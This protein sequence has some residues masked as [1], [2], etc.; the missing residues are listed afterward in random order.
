ML[1]DRAETQVFQRVGDK[2]YQDSRT[3]CI[4]NM[5]KG[6]MVS[7]ALG[8]ISKVKDNYC[9]LHRRDCSGSG[10]SICT[11]RNTVLAQTLGDSEDDTSQDKRCDGLKL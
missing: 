6:P 5:F 11:P 1:G 7:S 8:T 4:H 9:I 10:S 3:C 2:P